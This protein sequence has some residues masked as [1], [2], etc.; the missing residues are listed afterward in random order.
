MHNITLK[1]DA[2]FRR[3]QQIQ[4]LLCHDQQLY[5]RFSRRLTVL[6]KITN[7]LSI[8]CLTK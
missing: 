4:N 5:M 3:N 2:Q 6:P 1:T 7:S 8:L